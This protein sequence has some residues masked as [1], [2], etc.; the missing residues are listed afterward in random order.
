MMIMPRT[1][2]LFFK[3]RAFTKAITRS[4]FRVYIDISYEHGILIFNPYSVSTVE[5]CSNGKRAAKWP[6]FTCYSWLMLALRAVGLHGLVLMFSMCDCRFPKQVIVSSRLSTPLQPSTV[7][8]VSLTCC[9]PAT[10]LFKYSYFRSA[11]LQLLDLKRF[12][13]PNISSSAFSG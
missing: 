9:E 12:G 8:R 7:N 6:Y 11:I 3:A 4:P 1:S 2:S 10:P 5:D 13:K